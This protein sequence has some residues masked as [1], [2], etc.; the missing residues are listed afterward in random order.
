MPAMHQSEVNPWIVSSIPA[1]VLF[2][3][4]L[5]YL[6]GWRTLSRQDQPRAQTWRLEAFLAGAAISWIGWAP[7][8]EALTHVLL[9]AHMVQHLLLVLVGPPLLL[10]GS[11]FLFIGAGWTRLKDR[12]S[13]SPSKFPGSH[14]AWRAGSLITHPVAAALLMVAITITWHVPW[15]F[16]IAM[17]SPGW[18]FAEN[19]T[20]WASGILFWWPVILPWPGKSRWPRWTIPLYL[21]GADLPISVLSAYLAFCGEVI[22]PTYRAAPGLF[23]ISALNDQVAA[24]ML[25]WVAMLVVFL[26]AA[27]VV[28][29]DWLESPRSHEQRSSAPPISPGAGSGEPRE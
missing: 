15:V 28:I 25:M 20:F 18:Q 24:A 11:P 5:L 19:A 7:P 2:G 10:L 13:I 23:G 22:Y 26:G 8:L 16:E 29:F 1:A 4:I 14:F 17:H 3:L 27:V 9:I 12:E 21:L 6:R